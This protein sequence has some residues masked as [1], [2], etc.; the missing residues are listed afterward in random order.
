M[1]DGFGVR[2][3]ENS[4][5]LSPVVLVGG[6]PLVV[7]ALSQDAA[8]IVRALDKGETVAGAGPGAGLIARRL[9]DADLALPQPDESGPGLDDVTVVIPARNAASLLPRLLASLPDVSE[10]IVVD[11]G[12]ADD[13]GAVAR[14]HGARVLRREDGHGPSSARNHG[15]RSVRSPLA[16]L[17]DADVVLAPATPQRL[18]GHLADPAVAMVAPRVHALEGGGAGLIDRYEAAR[19]PLDLGGRAG[20]SRPGAH[21]AFVPSTVLLVRVGPVRQVGGFDEALHFG[22]DIDLSWRLVEA[23]YTVRYEAQAPVHHEHRV[24]A[25]ALLRRRAAYGGPAVELAI[26]HPAS[27]G[28]WSAPPGVLAAAGASLVAGPLGGAAVGVG[29]TADGIASLV[30]AGVA[31]GP[32]AKLVVGDHVQ[33]VRAALFALT[34]PWLP[35]A[36]VLAVFSSK[37]R[38]LLVASLFV[39]HA[40]DW[41]KS[42]PPVGPAAWLLLRTADDLAWAVGLWGSVVRSR[43]VAPLLP[44]RR[45]SR[46]M[47]SPEGCWTEL[48]RFG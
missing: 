28:A 35:A 13:T 40:S 20:R 5:W 3:H 31:V 29:S 4:R 41:R 9:L 8:D 36:L 38:R 25:G 23:G 21:P 45:H 32:A 33:S 43:R 19:S 16:L 17:V 46:L 12:S 1:P 42:R 14:A 44:R 27:A 18:V 24:K 37:V 6:S 26:R 30:A 39:R 34:R 7:V 10:V 48:A 11:D 22:E 15:L 47:T 2:L